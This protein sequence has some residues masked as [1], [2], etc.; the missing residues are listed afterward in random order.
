MASNYEQL[1]RAVMILDGSGSIQERLASAYRTEVQ[2]VG[3]EGLNEEMMD[4]LEA[5][6]DGLTS[7]EAA[8]DKDTIDMSVEAMTD[9][10]AADLVEQIRNVFNLSR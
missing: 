4:A 3:P 5:I 10:E 9:D 2:Y 6:N 7:V 1:K 8:G